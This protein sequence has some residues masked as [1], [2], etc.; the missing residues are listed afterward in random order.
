[1]SNKLLFTDSSMVTELTKEQI[2]QYFIH[3]EEDAQK[4]KEK[5]ENVFLENEEYVISTSTSTNFFQKETLQ[6]T[7][8]NCEPLEIPQIYRLTNE[9]T[10]FFTEEDYLMDHE[11]VQ[12][13]DQTK[14]NDWIKPLFS[15]YL[16]NKSIE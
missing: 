3:H 13:S 1:M 12:E 16:S 7:I 5:E 8:P 4:E 11:Y 2:D 9:K 14:T 10:D 6:L 15:A